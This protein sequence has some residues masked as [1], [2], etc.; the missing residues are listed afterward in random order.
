MI[1]AQLT[2]HIKRFA[3]KYLDLFIEGPLDHNVQTEKPPAPETQRNHPSTICSTCW[4]HG[5]TTEAQSLN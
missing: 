5:T 2:E 1:A 4:T 3:I